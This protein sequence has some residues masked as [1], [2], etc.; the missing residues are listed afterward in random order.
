LKK[1]EVKTTPSEPKREIADTKSPLS[2]GHP[3]GGRVP[4]GEIK[5]EDGGKKEGAAK[6]SCHKRPMILINPIER[7][8]EGSS[9]GEGFR[10]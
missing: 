9:G 5:G 6:A 7:K 3:R 10:R 1:G 4:G 8:K 2:K